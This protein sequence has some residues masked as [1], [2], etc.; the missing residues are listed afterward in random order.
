MILTIDRLRTL[1]D[2]RLRSRLGPS[3]L[4]RTPRLPAG[5]LAPVAAQFRNARWTRSSNTVIESAGDAMPPWADGRLVERTMLVW[6]KRYGRPVT[7]QEA[8]EILANVGRL[9]KA[10]AAWKGGDRS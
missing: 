8:L 3:L 4:A 6:S 5:W 10:L 7:E 1:S 9:A 2:D